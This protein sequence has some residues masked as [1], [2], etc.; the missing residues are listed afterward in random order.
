MTYEYANGVTLGAMQINHKEQHFVRSQGK[1]A[2]TKLAIEMQWNADSTEH[3]MR[4]P[5]VRGAPYTSMIY[6]NGAL[7]RIY[8]ERPLKKGQI[9]IDQVEQPVQCGNGRDTFSDSFRVER[10]IKIELDQSDM[11]WLVFLSSPMEFRCA[12]YDASEE[13]RKLNLPPGVIIDVPSLFDL[14]AVSS[15]SSRAMVR[16]AM[17]NNCTTGQNAQCK[18]TSTCSW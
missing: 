7:P 13:T 11:T 1:P 4:T 18:G 8:S 6:E 2:I 12:S 10:E 16:L 17:S 9:T 3:Q 14:Q 5:I 15:S